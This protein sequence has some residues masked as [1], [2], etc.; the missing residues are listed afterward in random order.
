MFCVPPTRSQKNPAC[1]C[2]RWR[3]PEPPD[4]ARPQQ[5]RD[6]AASSVASLHRVQLHTVPT[7]CDCTR[8]HTGPSSWV[9]EYPRRE[10]ARSTRGN[11]TPLTSLACTLAPPTFL[12]RRKERREGR[13]TLSTCW[14][15]AGALARRTTVPATKG[16]Q[17]GFGRLCQKGLGHAGLC[18]RGA[19]GHEGLG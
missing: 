4:H 17:S 10:L 14:T 3:D 5:G 11:R 18:Q 15:S 9:N 6:P 8:W 7:A 16:H 13:T 12:G 19:R 1:D 2:T